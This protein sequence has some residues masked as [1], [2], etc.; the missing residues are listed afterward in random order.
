MVATIPIMVHWIAPALTF[1]SKTALAGLS[2]PKGTSTFSPGKY[3]ATRRSDRAMAP[4]PLLSS[5]KNTRFDAYC[6]SLTL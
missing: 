2:G 4:D 3:C 1:R 5:P 6:E